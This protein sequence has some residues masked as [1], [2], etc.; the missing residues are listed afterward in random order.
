MNDVM[1]NDKTQWDI[2]ISQNI[3]SVTSVAIHLITE[4][5]FSNW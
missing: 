5:N 3:L 2:V 1:A 4:V